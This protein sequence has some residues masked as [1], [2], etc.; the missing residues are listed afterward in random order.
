MLKTDQGSEIQLW[1]RSGD[2]GSQWN[3]ASVN[4]PQTNGNAYAVR[5]VFTSTGGYRGYVALDD[6]ALDEC[7]M[8]PSLVPP[9][10]PAI[11]LAFPAGTCGF[12]SSMCHY[13]NLKSNGVDWVRRAGATPSFNTGPTVDHT[14]GKTSGHYV[15]IESSGLPANSTAM[16][17]SPVYR[18]TGKMCG[19]RF[20]YHLYGSD[21]G[22]LEVIV[23]D[24]NSHQSTQVWMR[25]GNQGNGWHHALVPIGALS[26]N[27]QFAFKATH[28]D[29][30]RGDMAIDDISFSLCDPGY[31]YPTCSA[32]QYACTSG[33]CVSDDFVCD[34]DFDCNDK[35]D[36]SSAACAAFKTPYSCDFNTS[37]CGFVSDPTANFTW[38]SGHGQTVSYGTG[39]GFDHTSDS[40]YGRYMYIEASYPRVQGENALLISPVFKPAVTSSC[41]VRL[42]YHMHGQHIGSFTVFMRSAD[43]KYSSFGKWKQVWTQSGTQGNIWNRLVL[44]PISGYYQVCFE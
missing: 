26:S 43:A 23:Q 1:S 42:F 8:R 18:S 30:F 10:T 24:L 34:N 25:S 15:Y 37:M 28:A 41:S 27:H 11:Q 17:E 7:A 5:F 3:Q 40:E 35:S 9:T 2:Q 38:I 21:I 44:S 36:E 13:Y 20:A 31:H 12:E 32:L 16:L 39:P 6:I 22:K 14:T 29:G 33:Q 4:L 19:M